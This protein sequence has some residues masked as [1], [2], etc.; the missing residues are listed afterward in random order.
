[1]KIKFLTILFLT[2]LFVL[3]TSR[4]NAAITP[5]STQSIQNQI[6]QLKNKIASKVAEL[7]LVEK[8][9]VI[10]TVSDSS[11]TQITLTDLNGNT[12]GVDVDEI[13]KFNSSSSNTFGISDIKKGTLLGILGL[14]NKESRRIL[15]RQ[16]NQLSQNPKIIFGGISSI[17]NKNFELTVVKEN[18]QKT[19]V[20]VTD[21]TKST[22]Y[23][24]GNLDKFGFSKIKVTNT[25]MAIGFPDKND[26]DKLLATRIIILPNVDITSKINLS[27]PEPTLAPSTGSGLKLFPIKK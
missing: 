22:S 16:V 15:A 12:R 27:L 4:I 11:D 1:M 14:Y 21:L 26:P 20:E 19:V 24:S 13:T 5:T 23:S 9:G 3:S 2:I 8:K 7:N 18:E 10:G 25:I 6:D 17:D